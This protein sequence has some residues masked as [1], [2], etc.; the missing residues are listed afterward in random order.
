MA[1]AQDIQEAQAFG[2]SR[3]AVASTMCAVEAEI[4]GDKECGHDCRAMF[5]WWGV[6]VLSRTLT[7]GCDCTD[8][9][10]T[11]AFACAVIRLLNP[12]CIEC[13]CGSPD[14]IPTSCDIVADRSVYQALDASEQS[15]IP[16]VAGRQTLIVSDTTDAGNEWADHVGDIAT[17]DGAGNYTYWTPTAGLV[18]Y[19]GAGAA[20]YLAYAGGVGPYFPVVSGNEA[21][22][23]LTLVSEA[24]EVNGAL[25]RNVLIQASA[26][27]TTWT[28]LYVGPED[29]LESGAYVLT[30]N[31]SYSHL[32]CV[33]YWGEED[34]CSRMVTG[35][36]IP[37]S[38]C[39]PLVVDYAGDAFWLEY[40]A[41]PNTPGA[42]FWVLSN[43]G[44]NPDW[45]DKV[46]TIATGDGSTWTYSAYPPAGSMIYAPAGDYDPDPHLFMGTGT[47][48]DITPPPLF[49]QPLA[50]NIDQGA[51]TITTPWSPGGHSLLARDVLIEGT[52]DGGVTWVT[53]YE[54]P[55]SA[56]DPWYTGTAPIGVTDLRVTYQG[57]CPG[58][59]PVTTTVVPY[60]PRSLRMDLAGALTLGPLDADVVPQS[61]TILAISVGS[62]MK[63]SHSDGQFKVYFGWVDGQMPDTYPAQLLASVQVTHAGIVVGVGGSGGDGD[64]PPILYYRQS[65]PVA[66]GVMSD[67]M[68]HSIVVTVNGPLEDDEMMHISLYVDGVKRALTIDHAGDVGSVSDL[69]GITWSERRWSRYDFSSGAGL[70]KHGLL[71]NVFDCGGVLTE[72]QITGP[73]AIGDFES[74]A[75][76]MGLVGLCNMNYG[77][78]V[79]GDGYELG[80]TWPVPLN[81]FVP[82][83]GPPTGL[84]LKNCSTYN[85][86]QDVPPQLAIP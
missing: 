48:T 72:G 79:I 39:D 73:V 74:N 41:F 84:L 11:E 50:A 22:G 14:E 34:E 12:G 20:Y 47:N 60:M 67:A 83:V 57:T 65:N 69:A 56:L 71:K 35:G 31:E 46:G 85:F 86:V 59:A 70:T 77:D 49:Y 21:A 4:Y 29:V 44:M 18:I 28:S 8:K 13:G 1:L 9:C 75:L 82:V 15:T 40:D 76:A 43:I 63:L 5:Y 2:Y 58:S 6:D 10:V 55:E 81:G 66:L 36:T 42:K 64:P 80:S 53:I 24:P 7:E 26:D 37:L 78:P 52:A 16:H 38:M 54:G 30:V 45:D 32:R 62:Y 25:G 23:M 61:D 19:S 51:L 33:Y 68:W 17:D 27:G 3:C